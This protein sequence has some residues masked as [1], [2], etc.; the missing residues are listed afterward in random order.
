MS[1]EQFD[2]LGEGYYGIKGGHVHLYYTRQKVDVLKKIVQ[3]GSLCL[4]VGCGTG[5]HAKLL[6]ENKRCDVYG[7]DLSNS[8]ARSANKSIG[9]PFALRGSA[10]G[11]PYK[12]NTIDVVYTINVLHHLVDRDVIERAISEMARVSKR[13]VVIFEFN[14]KNPFCKYLLFKVCPYDS[15]KER[16]PPKGEV[17]RAAI[18]SGLTV[19]ESRYMSFMPM[20]CPKVLMPYFTKL[21]TILEKIVPWMSV[22]MVYVLEKEYAENSDTI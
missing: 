7:M 5:L 15:G 12:D 17:I 14:S 19:Q 6:K 1:N 22:G 16:I 3:D 13:Y 4:D 2:A 18:D 21:E 8:M 9:V 11:I 10:V 20:M